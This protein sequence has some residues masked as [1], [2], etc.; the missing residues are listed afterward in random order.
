MFLADRVILLDKINASIAAR[1]VSAFNKWK[2]HDP[3]RSALMQKELERILASDR[4]SKGVYEVVSKALD[5]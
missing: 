3:D 2:R 4:L 1:M 5:G